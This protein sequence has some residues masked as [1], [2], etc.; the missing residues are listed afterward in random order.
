MT[1]LYHDVT[2]LPRGDAPLGATY[3]P[4]EELLPRATSCRSTST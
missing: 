1:I 3:L 4:L 2:P